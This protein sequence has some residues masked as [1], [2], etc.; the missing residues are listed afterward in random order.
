MDNEVRL[1][2]LHAIVEG[3]VQ[4]VSFRY[5]VRE[6]A[7]FLGITGWVRNRSDGRVEVTAEGPRSQLELLVQALHKGP[8]AAYVTDVSVEWSEGKGEFPTFWVRSTV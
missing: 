3:R 5:F 4:G 1:S 7:Y 6:Q 8:E 2:R